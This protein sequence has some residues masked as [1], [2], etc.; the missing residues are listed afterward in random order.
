M[1]PFWVTHH[2]WVWVWVWVWGGGGG[3]SRSIVLENNKF[4]CALSTRKGAFYELTRT[5][6]GVRFP[7]DTDPQYLNPKGGFHEDLTCSF[8]FDTGHWDARIG[9]G[10]GTA[11][12][13][14]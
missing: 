3:G 1:R 7:L 11:G 14:S 10:A 8:R 4:T 12:E 9:S 5:R 6:R 2:I 13:L